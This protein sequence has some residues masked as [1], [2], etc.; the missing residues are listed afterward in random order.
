VPKKKKMGKD[1]QKAVAFIS[2]LLQNPALTGLTPLQKEEQIL[3]FLTKNAS[4]LLP[5]LTSPN[6]FPGRSREQIWTILTQNLFESINTF[7]LQD[8][9][10]II[11][12]RIGFSFIPFFRQ[13]NVSF[14]QI[15]QAL[16]EFITQLLQ[17][18]EARRACT[19]PFTALAHNFA[20]SYVH[21]AFT[22]KEYIHF[23]LTKVQRIKLP[24]EETKQLINCSIL[25]RPSIYYFGVVGG[26]S[27]QTAVSG[28][29]QASFAQK[30]FNSLKQHLQMLPDAV[31]HSGVNSNVSF[32]E[33]KNLEATSRMTAIF[34]ARCRN[35][36][37]HIKVDRGADT[38][39]K[40]WFSIARRNYRFYGY[41]I[42]MLDEF[43]KIAAE[44]G[45]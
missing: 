44:N 6:F 31:L 16:Y 14:S 22:R 19:G 25:L 41:D 45:W 20:E 40:S 10:S 11:N 2:R 35:Y 24:R 23:E 5:T 37:P 36:N 18:P 9:Q 27:Q 21:Q 39:D 30:A 7:L 8:L 17:K 42:K 33:N 29:V 3:Q 43:F 38:A 1:N 12:D 13:Q 28:L 34:S 15:K 4:Q 32:Q 26:G